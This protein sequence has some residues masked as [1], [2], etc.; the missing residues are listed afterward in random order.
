MRSSS[1]KRKPRTVECIRC[2]HGFV[3]EKPPAIFP[4]D[5]L[6]CMAYGS[7]KGR[8]IENRRVTPYWCPLRERKRD[9]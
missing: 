7:K 5:Y 3:F 9:E 8:K 6:Y 4:G 2:V 1:R